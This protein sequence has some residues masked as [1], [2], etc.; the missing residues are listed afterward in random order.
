M[1]LIRA[2]ILLVVTCV[3][4]GWA[5]LPASQAP[6]LP[7]SPHRIISLVPSVTEML[8]AIGAGPDVVGVSS[9]DHYPP[10]AETRTNVGGLLDPDFERILTLRPDLVVVYGTQSSLTDRLSRAGIP[11]FPYQHAGLPDITATL[12]EIGAR[13]GRAEASNRLARDIERQLSEIRER[14]R[15]LAKP[16][17]MIVF[18]REAGTLRGMFAS[19]GVGFLHDMLVVAGGTNVFADIAKQSLQVTTEVALSKAPEVILELHSGPGWTPAR[20]SQ[21]RQIWRALPSVPAVRTG[22]IYLLTDELMSIPGPRVVQA[23]RAMAQAL[24][25]GQF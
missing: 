7:A 1:R 24:H 16:K 19:G 14:T 20:I 8:F 9:F 21:E 11:I 3:I 18:E 23:V 12:R 6:R 2:L 25:P 10:E 22:R 5:L 15:P 17:T 4:G 13:I